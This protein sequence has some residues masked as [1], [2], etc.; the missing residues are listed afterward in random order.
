MSA[1]LETVTTDLE[2]FVAKNPA[3]VKYVEVRAEAIAEAKFVEMSAKNKCYSVLGVS[4]AAGAIAIYAFLNHDT[5]ALA[6]IG[7]F[8]APLIGLL[9]KYCGKLQIGVKR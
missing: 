8:S 5:Y 3:L 1:N 4:I 2:D 6:A 9:S 7:A